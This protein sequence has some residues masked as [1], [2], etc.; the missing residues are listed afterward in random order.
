M[1]LRV[2]ITV[3][4]LSIGI[5]NKGLLYNLAN[6]ST[7][8]GNEVEPNQLLAHSCTTVVQ[9]TPLFLQCWMRY[10]CTKYILPMTPSN[11]RMCCFITCSH[12]C[13]LLSLKL[14]CQYA[15]TNWI[16]CSIYLV[17]LEVHSHVVGYFYLCAHKDPNKVYPEQFNAPV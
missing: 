16:W 1:I 9:S 2:D 12:I 17:L 13:K 7:R 10:Q 8:L 15:T 11:K 14:Y 6:P 5:I 4:S 3:A